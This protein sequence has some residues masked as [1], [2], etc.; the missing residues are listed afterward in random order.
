MSVWIKMNI[1]QVGD[2]LNNKIGFSHCYSDYS[3]WERAILKLNM[4]ER[5]S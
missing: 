3:S 1:I 2:A 5:S 4:T